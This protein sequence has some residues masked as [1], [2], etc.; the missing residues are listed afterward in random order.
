MP[1]AHHQRL[2]ALVLMLNYFLF[3]LLLNSVG[4]VILQSINSF[5]ISKESAAVLEGFKDIPIAIVSFFVAALLPRLGYRRAMMIALAVVVAACLAMPL[6]REFWASKL[7]FLCV[8]AAFAL[9]KVSVYASI[10]LLTRDKQDHASLMNTIEGIFMLGVLSGYW[11]FG[12]FIDAQN[13]A[14]LG[15]L[16]TY[17]LLATICGINLLVMMAVRFDDRPARDDGARPLDDFIAMLRLA[18]RPLVYTFVFSLFLYVL[19]EQGIGS[20]L[21][22]FN[23]QVL[24]LPASIS[25]QIT[26]LFALSLALG[27]LGAGQLL[28][29]IPWHWLLSGCVL[30]MATLMLL[31]LPLSHQV[32]AD[33]RAHWFNL[34]LVAYLFPLIGLFMA[35]IYPVLNSV[36]LSALPRQQ[37]SSMAGLIILFSALGGTTGSMITGMMFSRF[38]GQTAF[39]LALVPMAIILLLLFQLRRRTH[40]PVPTP[41]V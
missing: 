10:G 4:I 8:G 16:D 5:G 34:P 37:Q 19:I 21:P 29:H 23:N 12:A 33:P 26:S 38:S 30:A 32:E 41:V 20:W 15:W 13:P 1:L 11:L 6:L 35:P 36:V 27:R 7:F 3:G 40:E 39:Y 14:S 18:A 22:T 28:K 2:I 25:V 17:W 31:T 9:V 24:K